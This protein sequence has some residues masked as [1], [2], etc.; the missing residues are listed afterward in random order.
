[1][2][3][4]GRRCLTWQ[5][6]FSFST[7]RHA[8]FQVKTNSRFGTFREM[9]AAPQSWQTERG[10]RGRNLSQIDVHVW[11]QSNQENDVALS[12]TSAVCSSS[13]LLHK[14]PPFWV[15][16]VEPAPRPQAGAGSPL[17]VSSREVQDWLSEEVPRVSET[18]SFTEWLRSNYSVVL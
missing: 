11:L 15:G 6:G 12:S 5:G 4:Q 17:S 9:L 3:V 1:M 13:E 10:G 14:H 16:E 2:E 18:H 8:L 7:G